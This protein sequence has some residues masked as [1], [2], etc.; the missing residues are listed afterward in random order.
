MRVIQMSKCK[1]SF[2]FGRRV[3]VNCLCAMCVGETKLI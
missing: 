2:R 1:F 3:S